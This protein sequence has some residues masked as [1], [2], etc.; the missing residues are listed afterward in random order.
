MDM[1]RAL[2]FGIVGALAISLTA[3]ASSG[4]RGPSTKVIDRVL[5]KAPGKA[6]PSTIVSTELAYA[7]PGAQVHLSEGVVSATAIAGDLGA[8]GLQTQWAP[9]LV[10]Q[11]CDGTLALS[12][13][14]YADAQ[15]KV[16]NYV[17]TW[18]RQAEGGFKWTYDAAG[19]D[20]P[21]PP[22]RKQF[23]DGDIVVT[24]LDVVQGLIATC[25][26]EGEPTPPPPPLPI[27]EGGATASQVS[28][29][30]TLR[31]RWEHR[32]GGIKY[33]TAEYYFEGEWV[34]A[35]EESLASTREE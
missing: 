33:V 9:R 1:K 8:V 17:T 18:V 35:I 28:R 11:S 13:G 27:G 16:G 12:Q 32:A 22:P 31:W 23:E 6:Q 2:T 29:D 21:Q 14:R 4:P 19:L 15:G 7:Q 20:N 34:T 30:G 10:V 5:A 25:P 26:R 24:A 3:C